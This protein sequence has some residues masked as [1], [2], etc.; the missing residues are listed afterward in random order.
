MH[1]LKSGVAFSVIALWFGHES[2]T[3]TDSY[4]EAN[5]P[6][7]GSLARLKGPDTKMRR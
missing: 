5:P 6:M 1:R 7:K 4:V 3:T 2:T